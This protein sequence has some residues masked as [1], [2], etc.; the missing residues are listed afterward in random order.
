MKDIFEAL[1][2]A[3][4]KQIRRRRQ[5]DWVDPMLATLVREPFSDENWIFEP[6]VDGIRCLTFR[7]GTRL[8]LLSRNRLP[9]DYPELAGPLLQQPLSSFV[10]DGEIAALDH[11]VSRFSLLQKRRQIQVPIFY[12]LFDLLYL[13][14]C[15]LTHL[16]LRY[17]K[18]LLR[19]A[20]HFDD[21]LR[22]NPFF[23]DDGEKY[24]QEACRKGWEGV[25]AKRS[26]A[27]Y[28]HGRSPDWLKIK[29]EGAQEFVIVGYTE[30]AGK[31]IGIG[32]LLIGFYERGKLLYAGKV[33]TGFTVGTL[34]ELQQKLSTFERTEPAVRPDALPKTGVHWVEPRLVAQIAFSEWTTA[35]KLRHPRFLGLR[36]DKKASEVV[37]EKPREVR[38]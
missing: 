29:C 15:D 32:A 31:R 1:P 4:R 37:R 30:P 3:V 21:P 26:A 5:P 8:T 27:V 17:R 18:Q 20:F 9:L 38:T 34:I 13:E 7:K 33:G 28:I 12:F 11:G 24:F 25:I 35:G 10:V 16:E 6:K 23:A 36:A 22:L 19:E 2:P 14:G